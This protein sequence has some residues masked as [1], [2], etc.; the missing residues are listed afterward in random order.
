MLSERPEARPE[1]RQRGFIILAVITLVV[2]V[3]TAVALNDRHRQAELANRS[4]GVV[5]P[6]L[7][8]LVD[9]ISSIEVG[10][11]SGSFTLHRGPGGWA[12]A[13]VGGF[14]ARQARIEKMIGE[15]AG[16]SYVAAKTS[17][18][19]L[20]SKL[21]VEDLQAGANSTQLTVK[22][23]A[24]RV[25]ANLI[26]GKAKL[27]VAGLDRQ[28][29][30]IRIPGQSRAWLAEGT[31]DVRYDVA[32]W[33]NPRVVDLPASAI[34]AMHIT[35]HDGNP[36]VL[37]RN[38]D[39]HA[40]P[41]SPLTIVQLPSNATIE[42][43]YQIDYI[44]GLLADVSFVDAKPASE[45]DLVAS[46]GVQAVVTTR[47]GLLIVLRSTTVDADGSAWALLYA[48]V[49]DDAQVSVDVRQQAS[50]IQSKF[51]NWAIK[52]PPKMISKLRIRL[53]DIVKFGLDQARIKK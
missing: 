27:N 5:F 11:A 38:K 3:A 6:Q 30:Y 22:N 2:S 21:H 53:E 17:R 43:Q 7:R 33:S 42:N 41:R 49:V 9:G 40:D 15:L 39:A 28:G 26:V 45:V 13:G 52:L 36:L 1:L 46:P 44:A 50:S 51:A 48:G 10:R 12:N 8:Q 25:L 19:A 35:R 16:L 32:D 23:S 34:A 18:S 14:P 31:L 20:Y 37:L 4:G 24:G 29:V 47:N